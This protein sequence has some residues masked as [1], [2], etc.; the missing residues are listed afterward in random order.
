MLKRRKILTTKI[1][2]PSLGREG[3]KRSTDNGQ[4]SY[5]IRTIFLASTKLPAVIRHM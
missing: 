1:K 5:F 3:D 2:T 4:Q